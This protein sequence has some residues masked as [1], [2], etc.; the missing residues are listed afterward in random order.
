MRQLTSEI[1]KVLAEHGYSEKELP[2]WFAWDELRQLLPEGSQA[3]TLKLIDGHGLVLALRSDFTAAVAL[4]LDVKQAAPCKLSYAGP[5]YRSLQQEY[6]AIEQAGCERIGEGSAED[7]L[8]LLSLFVACLRQIG[9][10]GVSIAI[11]NVAV[12]RQ[13]TAQFGTPAQEELLAL[14]KRRSIA[15][16]KQKLTELGTEGRRLALYMGNSAS[17]VDL[18]ALISPCDQAELNRLCQVYTLLEQLGV[19]VCFDLSLVR[20]PEYYTGLVF[21]CYAVGAAQAL[22]GGGRYDRLVK[23]AEGYLPAAGFAL[24]IRAL[25][26]ATNR[27]RKSLS[28]E[29]SGHH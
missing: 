17:P 21:E 20:E 23:G 19:S 15:G 16:L 7:D 24:D 5:V 14:A 10:S 12:L 9:L 4:G 11:N 13:V 27:A 18:G 6:M 29:L 8:E 28:F 2:I 3:S 22:G 26:S 25:K 1:I